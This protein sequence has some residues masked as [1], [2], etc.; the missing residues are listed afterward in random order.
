M[1][2]PSPMLC[3]LVRTLQRLEE[4]D[5]FLVKGVQRFLRKRLAAGGCDE[6]P[7]R[8]PFDDPPRNSGPTWGWRSRRS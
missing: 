5:P 8:L 1:S 7:A 3:E 6:T 2:G 4:K